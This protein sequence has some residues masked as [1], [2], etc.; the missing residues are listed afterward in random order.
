M[1]F[2]Y[3]VVLTIALTIISAN[4]ATSKKKR[5]TCREPAIL[6]DFDVTRILGHWYEYSRHHHDFENGCD[7]LT[8]E[9][10]AVDPN[11]LQVSSCCQ[12]G[13]VSNATQKCNIGI[14]RARLTNPEK[15]EASFQYTR[16]GGKKLY[17][18]FGCG[19]TVKFLLQ[20]RLNRTF[21]LSTLIMIII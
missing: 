21:G 11:T 12:M 17:F 18:S 9:V 3:A 4:A 2:S 5:S 15:K 8:S 20:Y 1:H 19:K 14:N 7:C 13:G 16:T 10:V 6:Q